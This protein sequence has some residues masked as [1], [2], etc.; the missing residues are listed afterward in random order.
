M[1]CIKDLCRAALGE[2][3]LDYY[4]RDNDRDNVQSLR[5]NNIDNQVCVIDSGLFCLPWLC[6]DAVWMLLPL[7]LFFVFPIILKQSSHIGRSF[8]CSQILLDLGDTRIQ[9]EGDYSEQENSKSDYVVLFYDQFWKRRF[10]KI[11]FH[12]SSFHMEQNN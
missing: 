1:V 4:L 5:D 3:A 2:L 8:L 12:V 6:M 9:E 11:K 10:L 7:L